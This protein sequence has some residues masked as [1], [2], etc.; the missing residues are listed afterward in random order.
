MSIS[1]EITEADLRNAALVL[2]HLG[3]TRAEYVS[4]ESGSVC[5]DG[6]LRLATVERLAQPE[7][8]VP[9]LRPLH[10]PDL[11]KD[12]WCIPETQQALV[13]RYYS[14]VE[15]LIDLLP[16][17][18]TDESHVTWDVQRGK[19]EWGCQAN[20]WTGALEGRGRIHHYNDWVCTGGADAVE[21]LVQAAEKVRANA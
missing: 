19:R 16:D 3:H 4:E 18:C 8:E 20:R 9:N 21:L 5:L 1:P 14:A 17:R 10:A 2:E 11:R 7:E 6:A 12:G 13:N 15:M